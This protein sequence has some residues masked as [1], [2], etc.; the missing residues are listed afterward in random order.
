MIRIEDIFIEQQDKI[1][2]EFNGGNKYGH[3]YN[4]IKAILKHHKNKGLVLSLVES[5]KDKDL[6]SKVR[7]W[8]SQSSAEALVGA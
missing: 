3:D 8:M 6:A 5:I 7:T 4:I 1:C 2:D